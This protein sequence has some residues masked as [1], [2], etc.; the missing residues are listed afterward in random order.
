MSSRLAEEVHLLCLISCIRLLLV[1]L[2]FLGIIHATINV[3]WLTLPLVIYF[4]TS[5]LWY[6]KLLGNFWN[7]VN[8][9][10]F[11][12]TTNWR[13]I[14]TRAHRKL[15][16]TAKLRTM[17]CPC[18]GP[19]RCWWRPCTQISGRGLHRRWWCPSPR[20]RRRRRRR[21]EKGGIGQRAGAR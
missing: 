8:Q 13:V 15:Q 6:P 14:A 17:I 18:R 3:E 1:L 7:S 9:T 19:C 2:L 5:L 21:G 16:R 20:I 4:L 10:L 11:I 12:D